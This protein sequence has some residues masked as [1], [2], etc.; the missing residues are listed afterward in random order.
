MTKSDG[1]SKGKVRV[2]VTRLLKGDKRIRQV[3]EFGYTMGVAPED[4]YL[5]ETGT[6]QSGAIYLSDSALE[7]ARRARDETGEKTAVDIRD[8]D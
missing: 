8:W 4:G 1:N 3:A 7:A 6:V 5:I 2:S